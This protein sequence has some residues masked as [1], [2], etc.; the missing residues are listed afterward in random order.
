MLVLEN[1]IIGFYKFFLFN[2]TLFTIYIILVFFFLVLFSFKFLKIFEFFNYCIEKK[3]TK[4]ST[5]LLKHL[6]SFIVVQNYFLSFNRIIPTFTKYL[7]LKFS[8]TSFLEINDSLMKDLYFKLIIEH[9]ASCRLKIDSL[10]FKVNNFNDFFRDD[11]INNFYLV[12]SLSFEKII[13][14]IKAGGV[15]EDM[16]FLYVQCLKKDKFLKQF[17][18]KNIF[19]KD[20]HKFMDKEFLNL[21]FDDNCFAI[22]DIINYKIKWIEAKN[23]AKT[24]LNIKN[25]LPVFIPKYSEII[26]NYPKILNIAFYIKNLNEISFIIKKFL[27]NSFF[28]ISWLDVENCDISDLLY[29]LNTQNTLKYINYIKLVESYGTFMINYF[30]EYTIFENLLGTHLF[31]LLKYVKNNLSKFVFYKDFY[32]FSIF[33]LSELEFEFSL[34]IHRTIQQF[35]THLIEWDVSRIIKLEILNLTV[36]NKTFFN[37]PLNLNY[38][39]ITIITIIILIIGILLSVALFTLVERKL[40]AAI[41]RR[42]GPNVIGYLGIIQPLSDGLKLFSKETI[43]PYSSS[44]IIFIIAP[45]IT[46]VLSLFG[47]AVIPF[48]SIAVV[49]DINV[50]ILYLLAISSLSVYGIIMAGWSSNSKYSFLG[51]LRSAAQMISYEVS[52][53]FIIVT[54]GVCAGSF[55]LSDIIIVQKYIWYFIPLFPLFLMFLIS[56]LAETNRHPFDLPEAESELV[57]GYNVEY[58]AMPF[59]LFFLGEYANMLL[60][61]AIT[62]I[63]FLGGWLPINLLIL[64]IIPEFVWFSLKMLFGI[65]FFIWMRAALPRYRYDHLMYLGWK[66]FLPFSISYLMLISVILL[67]FNWLF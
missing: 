18:N 36:N 9:Y 65:F 26:V 28:I 44:K 39:I 5:D 59:A 45:T 38:I 55:R 48:S 24:L 8:T 67:S 35:V 52:I 34:Y 41:Q 43:F 51:A 14:K 4:N 1:A 49:A 2:N 47:W 19:K 37:I 63:F 32:L 20:L 16:L 30:F 57:S 27:F 50:G 29:I 46:F 13:D 22:I 6:Q 33:K 64:N 60:M 58:S 31:Y 53:S 54:I 3:L 56:I 17:I 25:F 11:L 66:C 21:N 10:F 42:K 7:Y 15:F 62:V 12:N 61:S 23:Y 40:L